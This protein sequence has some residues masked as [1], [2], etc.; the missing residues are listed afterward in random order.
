MITIRTTCPHCGNENVFNGKSTKDI[1]I[2]YLNGYPCHVCNKK[3]MDMPQPGGQDG[4]EEE[5]S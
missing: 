2:K 1:F 3:T 4:S 5:T